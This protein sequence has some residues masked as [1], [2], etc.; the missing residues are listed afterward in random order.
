M[1]YTVDDIRYDTRFP[2]EWAENHKTI[3]GIPTGP[4][5][6]KNCSFYGCINGVFVGYCSNCA[7]DYNFT[8]GKGFCFDFSEQ[9]MWENLDYMKGVYFNAI[10]DYEDYEERPE[11]FNYPD[12]YL[13]KRVKPLKPK[14]LKKGE[15]RRIKR[16]MRVRQENKEYEG[17]PREPET[18]ISYPEEMPKEYYI[19]SFVILFIL[20]LL[21]K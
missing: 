2:T 5:N 9:E 19:L 7:R 6:C 1:S 4:V 12:E 14:K 8:R 13:R 18:D 16:A 10:G 21:W 17:I 15:N 3:D 20:F 11:L